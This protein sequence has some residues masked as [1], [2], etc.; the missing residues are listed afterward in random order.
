MK[1]KREGHPEATRLRYQQNYQTVER[2]SRYNEKYKKIWL[3]R[4]STR[5][6]FQ[7]LE[8]LLATQLRSRVLLDLPS[9]G[10][11]L[12]PQLAPFADR[13]V[14]ADIA[15]G[16]ILVGRKNPPLSSPQIWMIASG[17]Q[18]PLRDSS[19]DGVVC[20]RLSH[21]LP[22]K[23]ERERLLKELIRVSRNFVIF[24]FFDYYSL[25]NRLRRARAF[26]NKKRPKNTMTVNELAK[27]AR[28]SG[29]EL[30]A[31][32]ALSILG[33]G[34]RYALIVKKPAAQKSISQAGFQALQVKTMSGK[35]EIKTLKI[36]IHP[37][38]KEE[39][40]RIWHVTLEDGEKA[41][42]KIYRHRGL[43]KFW[44]KT[45]F[46]CRVKREYQHLQ[47]LQQLG[48]PSSE[49]LFWGRG[50]DSD[51]GPFELL[52]TREIS[53]ALPLSEIL[54]QSPERTEELNWPLLYQALR[55]MHQSGL[56]H[57]ALTLKN[58]LLSSDAKGVESF[59]FIDMAMSIQ[60]RRDITGTRMA[61]FDLLQLTRSLSRYLDP[62]H[63]E[64]VLPES[65]REYL[66]NNYGM[67]RAE[68]IR[69]DKRLSCYRPT[70]HSRN[71]LQW[72]FNLRSVCRNFLFGLRRSPNFK[73]ALGLIPGTGLMQTFLEA[74]AGCVA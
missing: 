30:M 66:Q 59:F 41:V 45:N 20:V 58:I 6:E 73:K 40:T 43:K 19:V 13:L 34:H 68:L 16:Q 7:L 62:Q 4:L 57:G 51:L 64:T 23:E 37:I 72:E 42:V 47:F 8:E 48:I 15:M 9:G 46:R 5:R 52:A 53:R 31:S 61:W 28:S 65:H 60:F 14:E 22:A 71:R 49:P 21:H 11:R 63:R 18:I 12:S 38:K 27:L 39:N 55:R 25:K 74:M 56:Y 10:G 54:A 70:K 50:A 29:G 33:S 3:K 32:P 69:F 24:S 44:G 17:F 1:T 26:L 35:S 67:S 36:P 2:A